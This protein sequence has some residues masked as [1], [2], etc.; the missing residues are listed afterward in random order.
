MVA[1]HGCFQIIH[2]RSL[3]RLGE[4]GSVNL[5]PKAACITRA[6]LVFK[7]S[8][9]VSQVEVKAATML[10]EAIAT[11]QS[12]KGAAVLRPL[13]SLPSFKQPFAPRVYDSDLHEKYGGGCPWS[14]R[15]CVDCFIVGRSIL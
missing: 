11:N 8:V 14:Q 2:N 5:C 10:Y 4:G 13:Y 12:R 3:A 15:P 9:A 7:A 1:V 6:Y